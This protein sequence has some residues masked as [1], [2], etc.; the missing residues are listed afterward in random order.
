MIIFY[1][2]FL[3][4]TDD[5]LMSIIDIINIFWSILQNTNSELNEIILGLDKYKK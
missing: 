2:P 4:Q 3:W 1:M 5:I